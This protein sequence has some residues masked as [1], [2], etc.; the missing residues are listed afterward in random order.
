MTADVKILPPL[1]QGKSCGS[2][3]LVIEK[4]E[5]SS[6]NLLVDKDIKVNV[7]WWG[8]SKG[9]EIS[10]RNSSKPLLIIEYQ[11]KT[12]PIL[13]QAYLLNCEPLTI[14]IFSTSGEYIGTSKVVVN[15]Q[16]LVEKHCWTNTFQLL[17]SQKYIGNLKITLKT[18]NMIFK[19][20]I[21]SKNR[22]LNGKNKSEKCTLKE[23]HNRRALNENNNKQKIQ[24][25]KFGLRTNTFPIIKRSEKEEKYFVFITIL[26]TEVNA[27]NLVLKDNSDYF[28]KCAITSDIFWNNKEIQTFSSP[29][30]TSYQGGFR[31]YYLFLSIPAFPKVGS[32]T[33]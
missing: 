14:V 8:E 33:P 3:K 15:S 10:T 12:N 19:S 20:S 27:A 7:L 21:I 9:T 16:F 22:S 26:N 29:L 5:W 17:S 2:L 18:Q 13:F 11:I 4:V 31:K 1:L 23:S 25:R 30:K 32:A 24:T 6:G 28:L